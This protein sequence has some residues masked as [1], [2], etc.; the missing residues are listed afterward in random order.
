MRQRTIQ[1]LSISLFVATLLWEVY[2]ILVYL[3]I[4]VH[5]AVLLTDTANQSLQELCTSGS[6]VCRG[7]YA[8]FPFIVRTVARMAPF[9]WYVVLCA[10]GFAAFVGWSFLMRGSARITWTVRPWHI[11]LFFFGF[12]FLIF[13]VLSYLPKENEIPLRKIL[14]PTQS[15]YHGVNQEGLTALQDNFQRLKDAGC[16][17]LDGQLSNGANLYTIRGFCIERSFFTRVLPPL[18][19]VALLLLTFLVAGSTLLSWVRIR[20]PTLLLETTISVG[21]GAC[22]LV[23]LL[24]LMAVLSLHFPFLH[25]YSALGGWLL[26][27]AVLA[28]GYRALVT[29]GKRLHHTS[30]KIDLPWYNVRLFLVWL[31]LSYLAFNFLTV[32]RPFP[33]GWDDLGSYLNRPRLLVSYGHFI[34]SMAAFQWEYLT[35]LGFLLFGYESTFGAIIAMIINWTAG[36]LAVV[37]VFTFARTFLGRGAGVLSAL[38]YYTLPMVG[39]FSFAD[40][41]IDNAVFVM[42]ALGLLSMFLF[43]FS[44]DED[45]VA[46][47]HHGPWSWLALSA[48]FG[49]LAFAMKPTAIMVLMA[50]GSVLIG[51]LLWWPAF[52]GA[53]LL[54]FVVYVGQNTLDFAGVIAR[55]FGDPAAVSS[56][57]FIAVSVL[58][59]AVLFGWAAWHGRQKIKTTAVA[60]GLFVGVFLLA[61]SPWILHNNILRGRVIPRIDLGAPNTVTPIFDLYG[62]IDPTREDREVR[63]LPEDLRVDR[64]HPACKASGAEE[65][66]GRYWGFRQGWGHYLKLPWRTVMNIDSAGYYVMTMPALLLVPLL[67]LLPFFWSRRARWVRWLWVG[68]AFMLLQWMVLANGVVWYGVGMFLGFVVLLEVLAARP[69]DILNRVLTSVLLFFSLL[70]VLSLRMWQFESQSNLLEYPMGKASGPVMVE[71]TIPYYNDIAD[72]VVSRHAAMPDQP[73]LYRIG[74]FIPYFI[75]RNYEVIG[76]A[77]HQ[78]DFFNCLY[79]ERDPQITL[80][81]LQVLGINSIVFDTNT[82]TIERDPNGSLHQKVSAFVDWANHAEL[83]LTVVVSDSQAGVAFVLLPPI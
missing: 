46:A 8:F 24:W 5:G 30:W 47:E 34:Y 55:V 50:L 64:E 31:L 79:Q 7:L 71:R 26:I 70:I 57:T 22:V 14:E 75:P 54:A 17:R 81:R 32:I 27:L 28:A 72:I 83:G 82:A 65:E 69:P 4:P 77:D 58:I 39:H 56:T 29:W 13:N 33:I 15:I 49:A 9:L 63:T 67:L 68:T 52:L 1:T 12:L 21:L 44:N 53:A 35:S 10:L 66:L 20:F 41:K 73:Y 48:F 60:V 37:T 61:I 62:T 36:L 45:E 59:A 43:L 42:G 18:L 76:L 74:T 25:L 40:M 23:I 19:F 16:L 3:G 78:L 38:L 2:T 51:A 11:F 6:S 80:K